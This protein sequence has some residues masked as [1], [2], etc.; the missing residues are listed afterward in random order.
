MN[1]SID[2]N[3]SNGWELL[4]QSIGVQDMINLEEMNRETLLQNI[5]NRYNKNIIYV[6]IFRFNFLIANNL[7]F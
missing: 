7:A 3:E 4:S 1:E 2:S 6:I 5:E